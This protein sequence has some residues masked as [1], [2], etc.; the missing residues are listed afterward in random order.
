MLFPGS[1]WAAWLTAIATVVLAGGVIV[2][3]KQLWQ[4][5]LFN[6]VLQTGGLI[7]AWGKNK[8]WIARSRID[9]HFDQEQNRTRVN[10][11]YA[12]IKRFKGRRRF[13]DMEVEAY[14]FIEETARLAEQMDIYVSRG[15][16]DLG[17]I[18]D[19]LGYEIIVLYYALQDVLDERALTEDL[20]YEGFRDLALRVQHY[21]RLHKCV[22][23][24]D[25]IQW[26]LLL[27]LRYKGGDESEG[28]RMSRFYRWRLKRARQRFIRE[29]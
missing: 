17:L 9:K 16:A 23:I 22:D 26:A 12:G 21:A 10:R 6:R 11:M 4:D 25:Q 3:V 8:Y 18:A 20:N 19:H 14:N 24:R 13:R 5:R 15:A 2:A 28:Y 27:P 29:L 1:D 7:K